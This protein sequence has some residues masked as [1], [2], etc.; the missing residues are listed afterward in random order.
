LRFGDDPAISSGVKATMSMDRQV[1]AVC[2]SAFA[3]LRTIGLIRQYLTSDA[4]KS[5]VNGLVPS[6]LDY[7]NDLLYGVPQ[8]LMHT[9]QRVQNC[10]ARI[11][12]RRSRSDHISPVLRD[13]HWLP[14]H[15]RVQFKILLHTYRAIHKQAPGYLSGLLKFGIHSYIHTKHF[16]VYLVLAPWWPSQQV[17]DRNL[18][19]GLLLPS[20]TTSILTKKTTAKLQKLANVYA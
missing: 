17:Y 4:T 16:F 5:L 14:V 6:C 7:C 3:Q 11:V 13:L 18:V 2:R 8:S 9:L 10:A 1:A 19:C 12:T 15:R 20:V